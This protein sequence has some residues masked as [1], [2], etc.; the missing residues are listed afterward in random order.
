MKRVHDFSW[1]LKLQKSTF[2]GILCIGPILQ[3]D[4]RYISH[5]KP[6]SWVRW[7]LTVIPPLVSANQF[8]AS[9]DS[10]RLG[11]LRK[12]GNLLLP[13]TKIF[14]WCLSLCGKAELINQ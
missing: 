10:L 3:V 13:N 9:P 11:F 5:V 14:L 4:K 7:G 1:G 2:E 12:E 8:Y 6:S